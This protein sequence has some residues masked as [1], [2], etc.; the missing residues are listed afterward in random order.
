MNFFFIYYISQSGIVKPMNHK[1]RSNT[2]SYLITV[3]RSHIDPCKILLQSL[4]QKTDKKIVLVGNLTVEEAYLFKQYRVTYIDEDTI[5]MRDRLP[6]VNWSE[7]YRGFGWYKQ[8]FIRLSIDRF[9]DT[10]QVVILD[11]EVFVF[12][13]WDESR[14]YDPQTGA[15][16]SFYWTPKVRKPDWDYKMYRGSAY[17]LSF[18]PECEGI[19]EYANSTAYKRHISGVGLFSTKNIANLWERLQKNTDLQKNMDLLFNHE[20]DLSFSEYEFYGQAVEYSL[21]KDVVPTI[22]FNDLLGWYEGHDDANFHKF[23]SNAMWSM[24]QRYASYSS[25][26]Y[27]KY[28][29]D[30][31][32]QL[33]SKLSSLPYWNPDDRA[34]IDEK[35]DSETG[36]EYLN[37][38]RVQLDVT[39]RTR[40]ITFFKALQ[41]LH[42]M[43]K[44]SP[45]LVEIGTLRDSTVGGGHS[46]YKFGEYCSRFGGTLYTIDVL[47]EAIA[48]SK[49]ATQVFSDW[50]KYKT[51]DSEQFFDEFDGTIDFLYLDGFDSLP[52]QEQLASEK[53]LREIQKAYPKLAENCVVLL[54]D[55]RLPF[56]GKTAY[57]SEYLI[58]KGFKLIISSYQLLYYREKIVESAQMTDFDISSIQLKYL[59]AQLPEMY[60]PIFGHPELTQKTSR[61]S[62]DRWKTIKQIQTVISKKLGRPLR[63]LDLGC[64]QGFFS[65]N[66]AKAGATVTG[67]DFLESNIAV[68]RAL[69]N[70]H[71]DFKVQFEVTKIEDFL[72]AV[73]TD[74]Y[75]LVLGLSVFHHLV[76]EHSKEVVTDWVTSLSQKIICGIFELALKSEPL[77]WADKLPDKP[78]EILNGFAFVHEVD[79]YK[80]HLSE[81]MRPLY[82]A[83]HSIWYLDGK[84]DFFKSWK[85]DS[86]HLVG[87]NFQNS[88]QY[89]M[90]EKYIAKLFSLE[91]VPHLVARNKEE[92]HEESVFL[93]IPPSEF[94]APH[95]I[96]AGV[97]DT[98]TWLVREFLP[99]QILS[100]LIVEKHDYNTQ[101][102]IDDVLNQLCTLEAKNLF[103]NDLRV[104]NILVTPDGHAVLIDYGDIS[105]QKRDVAWPHNLFLSFWIFVHEL[106]TGKLA[107]PIPQRQPFISPFNLPAPYRQWGMSIWGRPVSEWSFNRLREEYKKMRKN[108]IKKVAG[109]KILMEMHESS[110]ML[111]MCAMEENFNSLNY[112]LR[113]MESGNQKMEAELQKVL[114]QNALND[115]SREV[116]Q[117]E[118]KL[119]SSQERARSLEDQ[120]SKQQANIRQWVDQDNRHQV[121]LK[122]IYNSTSW[123][124]SRPVRSIGTMLRQIIAAP[125]LLVKKILRRLVLYLRDRPKIKVK[126]ARLL[127]K[128]PFVDKLALRLS[129]IVLPAPQN[130]EGD[131]Y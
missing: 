70:E 67:I 38:Y 10:D 125:K 49:N 77:Y 57:S 90:G 92:I 54:D 15:P 81:V 91:T 4:L 121:E 114:H 68:C 33:N 103:H 130:E 83:S 64:S 63:V 39:E 11:S 2:L 102:I 62:N 30:I 96:T 46:T 32:V 42:E 60:Q 27:I 111:W 16:C 100:D 65:L 24:C 85:Y 116:L 75:D 131:L 76:H 95:L 129:R 110:A 89:F 7:K 12:E 55:A 18:L 20:P 13:N 14:L 126:L 34:I 53:Q 37:K 41:T 21:F 108:N 45:V 48:F 88:R 124:I 115:Q 22:M 112:S 9:M 86:H 66:L 78:Q 74:Q 122:S 72:S 56:G 40:Y 109:H 87:N 107:S 99:G 101:Q 69:A 79:R 43:E 73:Q 61:S 120:I 29:K 119:R 17:L 50:I 6:I 5:D 71:P 117:L 26:E 31:A 8:Q 98:Q 127:A 25:T 106:T 47:E 58:S 23:K 80:T 113:K 28:M 104:W 44:K 36:I 59:V 1:D 118:L 84:A 93:R 97:S 82:F 128:T 35:Y 51:M 123:K 52:G 105:S 94:P 19:M 3:A